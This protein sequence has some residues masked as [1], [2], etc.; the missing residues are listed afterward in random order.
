MFGIVVVNELR[1]AQG[2]GHTCGASANNDDIGFH[3][4]AFNTF[5]RLTKNDH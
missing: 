5:K 2:A 3:Y 1:Q 4:G